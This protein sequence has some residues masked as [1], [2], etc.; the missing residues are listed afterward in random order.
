MRRGLFLSLVL[1]LALASLTHAQRS[2]II[3]DGKGADLRAEKNADSAV[4]ATVKPNAPFTFEREKDSEWAKVTLAAGQTGWIELSRIRLHFTEKDLPSSE[5]DPAGESEIE[6]FARSRGFQYAP[7]TRRAARG[8]LKALKEFFTI[9]QKAD[10]AAAESITGVPTVVYHLLGDEKFAKFLAAQPVPY[11]MMVRNEIL[12]DG[13][14]L[15]VSLYLRNHFP[16]TART[17]F[18]LEMVDWPSPN[19]LYALRK[20]FSHEFELGGSKVV[21]AELIEKKTG[22][23][24]CDLTADDIGT[25]AEREGEALW[26]PD[27]KRVACL[28][29][30]F[31]QEQ[32]S[33]FSTP[34]PRPHRKM[35]AVYQLTGDS[36]ARVNFDL[37]EVPGRK[38]D[39][40]LER[41][42]LGHVYTEPLRWLKP[43]VLLLQ[44]HEYYETLRPIPDSPSKLESIHPFGRLYHITVTIN[45]DKAAVSWKLRPIP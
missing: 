34:R 26:S 17:L 8:D 38:E 35:T 43:N 6:Q 14:L 13:P 5:K 7:G 37:S 22:R 32:G 9:A 27:S 4:V 41:A 33:L 31:N 40:E 20:V 3:N 21:Q 25:S 19:D 36:F 29:T 39:K 18:R 15:P 16:E 45:A 11:R 23:V 2:G 42:I 28:S 12:G 1:L 24:L 10:G 30:D 44:H